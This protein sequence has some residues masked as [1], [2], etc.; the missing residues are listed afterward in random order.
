MEQLGPGHPDAIGP[1]RLEGVL[2]AGGMGE[3]FLGRS[4]GGRRVAIKVVRAEIAADPEFR[5][6]FGREVEAARR[7]GGFWTAPVVDADPT[8]PR[9]WVASAFLDAP[10]LT[11]VV[12]SAGP[13]DEARVRELGA[14][15]AEALASVHAAGLIHRDLKPSNILVTGDGPRIIDFGIAK[16]MEGTALTATGTVVGTPGFMSPEQITGAAVAE[17]SDVFSLGAVLA[18]AATG[19]GPFGVGTAHSLLY[20]VVHEQPDLTGVPIGLRTVVAACLSKRPE[21]RPD[22]ARLLELLLGS[23]E[24]GTVSQYALRPPQPAPEPAPVR[25]EPPRAAASAAPPT[26]GMPADPAPRVVTGTASAPRRWWLFWLL[27]LLFA[28]LGVLAGNILTM[29]VALLVGGGILRAVWAA[30][31]PLRPLRI[32]AEPDGLALHWEGMRWYRHWNEIVAADLTGPARR[33]TVAFAVVEEAPPYHFPRRTPWTGTPQQVRLT[34]RFRGAEA[35]ERRSALAA[36]L[37]AGG[38][39]PPPPPVP[40]LVRA[41]RR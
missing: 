40:G 8:A 11:A 2:G 22:P 30:A 32:D 14:G 37:V 20:R 36:M 27:M 3:V 19:R 17:P 13:L 10:D 35:R 18:Y 33:S 1:Y 15:L 34:V 39:L 12:G 41:T 28:G 25:A 31:F 7:V 4:P 23:A 29:L 6:R 5:R 26:P 16:A 9:P 24:S 21:G 38:V